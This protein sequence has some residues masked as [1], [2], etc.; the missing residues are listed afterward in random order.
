MFADSMLEFI[1]PPFTEVIGPVL[2]LEGGFIGVRELRRK[3]WCNC[4]TPTT[5]PSSKKIVIFKVG[6]DGKHL[7]WKVI[8]R[9]PV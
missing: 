2:I 3:S 4:G 9:L 5:S 1:M 8:S 6:G 7:V